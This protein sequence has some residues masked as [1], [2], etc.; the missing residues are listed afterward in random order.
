MAAAIEADAGGAS[1]LL[2]E[3]AE[4]H[5]GSTALSGGVFYAAGTSVQRAAG[6]EG[7]TADAMFD[8]YLALN[9][10]KVE[11]SVVRRL[12]DEA[13]P[14]L[15]WL[16]GLGVEFP[17]EKLYVGGVE[18][19]ARSHKPEGGGLG[20][21]STLEREV[22]TRPIEVALANRVEGLLYRDGR[23]AGVRARGEDATAGGVILASGGFGPS[24]ELL[25]RYYPT[26]A[27][28][29]D[30]TWS[31]SASTC[32]GDGLRMALAVGARLAG[33][34]RGL[35]LRTAGFRKELEIYMPAW[36]V[37][38]NGHGRRFVKET[39]PYAVLGSV[40]DHQ[41]GPC[42]AIF[43]EAS[44]ARASAEDAQLHTYA[45]DVG[46]TSWTAELLAELA[47]AGRILRAGTVGELAVRAEIPPEALATTVA[48]HNAACVEGRDRSF[49][50]DP[51]AL[52]PIATPPFYA[53]E[54]RP[55]IVCLTSCGPRIDR[56]ARVLDENGRPI[57]G[58]YAAGEVAGNVLGDLYIGGGNSVANAIVFGRVAGRVAA[59]AAAQR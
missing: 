46:A 36:L 16:I 32:V 41:Q 50:K 20:I 43:D 42:Y 45:S 58:L 13:A 5:G 34:D 47:D 18:N 54:I 25:E 29:G 26:A 37:Y 2:V 14:T 48:D 51:S 10:W 30:W 49:F 27:A 52:R 22:R 24:P 44:R 3:T 56:D 53:A 55:A 23:V 35:L 59:A 15:E 39:A 12:C 38:V 1:V 7:D 57:P 11:P 4:K 31:I 8:Y 19:V 6:V 28:A 33:E 40:I 9:Q 21:T 17:I